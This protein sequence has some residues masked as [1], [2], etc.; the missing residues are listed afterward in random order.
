MSEPVKNLS[1]MK[2][3]SLNATKEMLKAPVILSATTGTKYSKEWSEWNLWKRAFTKFEVI[4]Y[5]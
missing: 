3:Y 4:W 2:H 5:A 1:C